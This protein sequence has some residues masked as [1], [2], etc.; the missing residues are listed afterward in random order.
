[1][2]WVPM[3]VSNGIYPKMWWS[4]TALSLLAY[5][6]IWRQMYM[7]IHICIWVCAYIHAYTFIGCNQ[8]LQEKNHKLMYVIM[9]NPQ[10]NKGETTSARGFCAMKL[11]PQK[12]PSSPQAPT[13]TPGCTQPGPNPLSQ[14]PSPSQT[15]PGHHGWNVSLPTLSYLLPKNRVIICI[16]GGVLFFGFFF[17]MGHELL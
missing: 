14:L 9:S 7:Y 11:F 17:L 8:Q 2:F 15:T 13:P 1:M 5:S 16:Y 6:R 10:S 12:T 4:L 3:V